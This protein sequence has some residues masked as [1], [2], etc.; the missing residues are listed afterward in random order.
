MCQ[1][2]PLPPHSPPSRPRISASALPGIDAARDHV[3]VVAVRGVDQVAVGKLHQRRRADRLVADGEMLA[4]ELVR[5]RD[6]DHR[7]LEAPHQQHARERFARIERHPR[8]PDFLGH[9]GLDPGIHL[10]C[11]ENG[12]PRQAPA[13][14]HEQDG[15]PH[16]A[17]PLSSDAR[18]V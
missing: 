11:E 8:L 1:V 10:S 18:R 12:L 2:P 6:V 14:T 13:M 7:L 5:A 9:A 3:A 4:P 16:I 17:A 15:I